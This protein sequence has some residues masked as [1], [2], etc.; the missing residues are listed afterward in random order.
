MP[1][2][3]NGVTPEKQTILNVLE[4]IGERVGKDCWQLKQT[5]QG[6]LFL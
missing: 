5:G 1:L 4:H 3:R 6:S 2:L